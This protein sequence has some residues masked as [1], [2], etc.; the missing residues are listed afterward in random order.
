MKRVLWTK[1]AMKDRDSIFDWIE[2]EAPH[3][4]EALDAMFAEKCKPLA[5][6]PYMGRPGRIDGTRELVIHS[7]YRLLYAVSEDTVRILR[8]LH[9]RRRW[10]EED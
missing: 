1:Q 8:L 7:N 6:H 5:H 10:R 9:A 3:A 2:Q 4:A